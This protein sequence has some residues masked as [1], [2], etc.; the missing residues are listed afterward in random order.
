MRANGA[1][2]RGARTLVVTGVLA[3]V[4]VLVLAASV[5]EGFLPRASAAGPA[6]A[7][8]DEQ[9]QIASTTHPTEHFGLAGGGGDARRA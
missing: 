5:V 3:L 7:G 6:P 1:T 4:A 9:P 2:R 8:S